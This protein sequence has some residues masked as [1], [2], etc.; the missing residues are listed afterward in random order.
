MNKL[1]VVKSKIIDADHLTA[2]YTRCK[3][4][5]Y[6]ITFTNGC[7]DILHRGHIE[8]LAQAASYGDKLFVGINTDDS[9]KRLKGQERPIMDEY[10]RF[11]QVA[12]LHFV[13]YVVPFAEDT[14]Y[15]LIQSIEPDI[16]VKGNEYRAENIVGY[17]LVKERGGEII[18]LEMLEGHSSSSLIQK[19][20]HL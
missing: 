1:N 9:V 11:L 18:T 7:F 10:S 12:S 16:L 4:K 2:V 14:P 3:F 19:L 13:D 6:R 15:E 5:N 8:Y 17:D 20:D